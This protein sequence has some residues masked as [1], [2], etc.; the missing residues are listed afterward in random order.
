[1]LQEN[2]KKV[3]KANWLKIMF[4]SSKVL[5]PIVVFNVGVI[6]LFLVEY[7]RNKDLSTILF[8]AVLLVIVGITDFITFFYFK[9]KYPNIYYYNDG[10]SVGKG[11]K[12][13]YKNLKYF[14]SKETYLVGNTFSEIFYKSNSGKWEKIKAGGYK[15]GAFS[16][17]QEDFVKQNYPTSLEK[18]ENGGKEE[19]SFRK[20]HKLSFNISLNRKQLENFENLQKISISKESITFDNEVYEWQDYK[21]GITDRIIYVK[22]LNDNIIL[23]LGNE[24]EIFCEN[25]LVFL[26][27]KF[28]IN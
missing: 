1:M 26:I 5:I 22:D 20:S 15:K 11:E 10:F 28:N 3:E 24:M 25:L 9:K 21:V 6:L 14:F 8:F 23:A 18:I 4:Y 16:L 17:F 27:E 13:Y 7:S 19:F 12:N 2:F